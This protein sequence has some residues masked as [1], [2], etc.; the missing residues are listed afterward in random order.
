MVA[1]NSNNTNTPL[2]KTQRIEFLPLV[3]N[4]ARILVYLLNKQGPKSLFWVLIFIL[5]PI[6]SRFLL[7]CLP[8]FSLSP[9]FLPQSFPQDL[10][11][12]PLLTFSLLSALMILEP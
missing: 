8:P 9:F 1:I 5:L 3:K 4:S 10:L 6:P 11:I 12:L 7:L 2:G